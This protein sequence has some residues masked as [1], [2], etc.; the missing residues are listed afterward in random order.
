M[1]K[2]IFSILITGIFLSACNMLHST[3]TIQA[4]D[5]FILGNNKHG[6]FSA[7]VTNVSTSPLTVW[8]YPID[9]GRHSP[10]TLQ[11]AANVKL[12]V[13]KNTALRI[14]NSSDKSVDVKLDVK[15]DIGLSMGY[16][17]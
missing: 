6:Q 10:L 2:S 8:Q 11:P 7:S 3:T 12:K 16:K 17:N 1:I 4:N 5:A 14:E 9:G 15:G 13:G